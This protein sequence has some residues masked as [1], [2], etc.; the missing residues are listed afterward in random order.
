[1]MREMWF[2]LVVL[3]SFQHGWGQGQSVFTVSGKIMTVNGPIEPDRMGAALIHEHVMVDWI[4]ADSTGYHRWDRDSIVERV[5]PYL[6]ELKKYGVHTFMDCTPA[7]LG[8]DPN[9]LKKL[10]DETGMHILTNT[11]YYGAQ[12]N[13]FTPK[14]AREASAEELAEQW[15]E[16]FEKGIDSSGIRPGFIK[17]SVDSDSLLSD[18]HKKLVRAAALTHLKT[19]LTIVS[20]TGPDGPALAQL[21]I[22]K[23]M[24]VS[25][26]AFVWTHAQSGTMKGYVRAAKQGAWI[27]LDNVSKQPESIAWFV[28]TLSK[29]KA[30]NLLN[31]VLISHDAGWYDV[32]QKNGGDFRPY[33]AVFIQLIPEL[34]KYG[35]TQ[36]DI[37]TLLVENPK[38]AYAIRIRVE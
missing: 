17:I 16:E 27:S 30:R 5:L 24:H 28:K 15:I 13:I 26:E 14:N 2:F 3:L 10:A 32:G 38:R 31:Q 22:L 20:H 33:T 9:I 34:K 1:M 36:K 37:D 8:R 11:G 7:F 23:E 19:G 6:Q 4:G 21:E 25:P 35:F 29:L 12:N 18:M